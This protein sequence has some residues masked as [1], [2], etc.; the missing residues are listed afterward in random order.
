MADDPF[1]RPWIKPIIDKKTG[2]IKG[3]RVLPAILA[4]YIRD[5]IHYLFVRDS[6]KQGVQRF[7]YS[8]NEGYYKLVSDDEVKGFIKAFIP[9]PIQSMRDINECL[10]LLYTD[11]KYYNMDELNT[12]ENIINFQN[13]VLELDTMMLRQHSHLDLCTIQIKC[14]YKPDVKP[15]SSRFD[16]FM[17][18]FTG[19]DEEVQSLLLQYMGVII[20]NI[21]GWRMKKALFMVGKSDAGKS[22][23]K[24]LTERLIGKGNYTA[25]DL[26]ELEARFGTSNIFNKRLAGSSDMSYMTIK[27]LK[28]FKKATGGDALFAEYKGENGFEFVFNGLLW[29]CC[30]RLPKFGGDKGDAVFNRIMVVECSHVAEK[31][32]KHLQDKLFAE[33]DYIVAKAIRE[34]QKVIDNGYNFIIPTKSQDAVSA[35]MVEVNSF[36]RFMEECTVSRPVGKYDRCTAKRFYDVYVAWCNDNNNGY[37]ESKREIKPLLEGV[38]KAAETTK[39][40]YRYYKAFTLKHEVKIE[41]AKAYD[42]SPET[43]SPQDEEHRPEMEGEPPPLPPQQMGFAEIPVDELDDSLPF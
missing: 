6:A 31:L 30:N 37:S 5:N 33:R 16:T 34:L 17:D 7:F 10:S 42:C 2:E 12:N 24:A 20:S 35:Y 15:A 43:Q 36:I 4:Q 38:G 32:D 41:Y 26:D 18:F 23:L 27:E 28:A 29:F 22:Q 19:G 25:V 1:I 8:K 13:G 3:H 40:G 14:N 11:L 39:D 21:Q 9:V